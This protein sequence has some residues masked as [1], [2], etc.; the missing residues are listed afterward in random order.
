MRLLL[1]CALLFSLLSFTVAQYEGYCGSAVGYNLT[2]FMLT[3]VTFRLTDRM[4]RDN[5]Y[6]IDLCF[7]RVSRLTDNPID[8]VKNPICVSAGNQLGCATDTGDIQSWS[9][10]LANLGAPFVTW[11]YVNNSDYS[12]G[13]VW[14]TQY[15]L[16]QNG[17]QMKPTIRL[18]CNPD[19]INPLTQIAPGTTWRENYGYLDIYVNVYTNLVCGPPMSNAS[20]SSTGSASPNSG[21]SSSA[22][23]G[24]GLQTSSVAVIVPNTTD[25]TPGCTDNP[26]L[27][28][29][30]SYF[31]IVSSTYSI[32]F[33][34]TFYTASITSF[35]LLVLQVLQIQATWTI[36]INGVSTSTP[37]TVLNSHVIS[38]VNAGGGSLYPLQGQSWSFYVGTELVT[39]G[40][41]GNYPIIVNGQAI[42][43]GGFIVSNNS[44]GSC[45]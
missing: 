25:P 20:Q 15:Y 43:S 33:S 4:N 36:T 29:Y 19:A 32:H 11:G 17:Y 9:R 39:I 24:P 23:G 45:L 21:L 8:R 6:Y 44:I 18:I 14:S 1:V 40:G 35:N 38:S 13:V 30:F 27:T 12:Q 26:H 5:F 37:V 41:N 22:V 2:H 7:D 31:A 42:Q 16:S 28:W 3:D 10:S 34:G